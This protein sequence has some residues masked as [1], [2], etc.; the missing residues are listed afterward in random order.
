MESSEASPPEDKGDSEATKETADEPMEAASSEEKVQKTET[1]YH[2][3]TKEHK[4]TYNSYPSRTPTKETKPPPAE[5]K[6]PEVE[7]GKV[8]L[9]F[10][11][12][13]VFLKIEDSGMTGSN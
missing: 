13:D 8:I 6:G 11:N 5:D 12:S 10:Y 1:T 7:E 2:N 9:D 4:T 3:K